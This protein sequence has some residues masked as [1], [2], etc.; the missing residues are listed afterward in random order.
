MFMKVLCA[1]PFDERIH[2]VSI[3]FILSPILWSITDRKFLVQTIF[4]LD[5]I[6]NSIC[7]PRLSTCIVSFNS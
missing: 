5:I 7:S 4:E 3:S 1:A 2:S 6:E